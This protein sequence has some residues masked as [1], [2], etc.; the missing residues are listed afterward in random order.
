MVEH[1]DKTCDDC[2]VEV[3]AGECY[4]VEVLAG[5]CYYV[6]LFAGE[7][8]YGEVF[9]GEGYDA[10]VF[11][12]ECYDS[13][14]F[15]REYCC[16]K[17]EF[18]TPILPEMPSPSTPVCRV[19]ETN[20][21]TTPITTMLSPK[22]D[23]LHGP[24]PVQIENHHFSPTMVLS[25]DGSTS[26]KARSV[27]QPSVEK[28]PLE[29]ELLSQPAPVSFIM[30][31]RLFNGD[32]PIEKGVESNIL[33]VGE[34]WILQT[35]AGMKGDIHHPFFDLELPDPLKHGMVPVF[36]HTPKALLHP[37]F[38]Q[39]EAVEDEDI[40]KAVVS[41]KAPRSEKGKGKMIDLVPQNFFKSYSTRGS[42][43][44][45]LHEAMAANKK[46]QT[47]SKEN[48]V[49]TLEDTCEPRSEHEEES[50]SPLK[51]ARG[52]KVLEKNDLVDCVD[53]Q[54]WTCLFEWPS[55]F[56][57][58]PEV[59]D[60]YYKMLLN[61]DGSIDTQFHGVD[62][63]LYQDTLGIILEVPCKGINSI[64]GCTPSKVFV[65]RGQSE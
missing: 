50:G 63:H 22:N 3:F 33:T 35:L 16:A 55:S 51:K 34:E 12:D 10:E 23:E 37:A 7:C 19:S 54:E 40:S 46:T 20:E 8:Y 2:D 56:L 39:R 62:I 1:R 60:F 36:D 61:E 27:S 24:I 43:K 38:V 11:A 15:V 14:V 48:L 52:G 57:H 45:L 30:F 17:F 29:P 47:E 28:Q 31:E 26:S 4:Y 42:Q 13:E 18:N 5:E 58:E 64:E 21:P 44:K 9:Y 25:L 65:R 41:H 59:Y 53:L 32:L 49:E 6:E